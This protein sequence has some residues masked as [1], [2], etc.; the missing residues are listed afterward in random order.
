MDSDK[1]LGFGR[2][3]FAWRTAL[4]VPMA[5]YAAFAQSGPSS[6][7]GTFLDACKFGARGDGKTDDTKA[8]QQALDAAGGKSGA[9]FVPPGVYACSELRMRR[10]TALVGIPA[11]GYG[12]TG[13]SVLK[14]I[15]KGARCL[16]NITGA[17][18]AT[19]EGLSLEGGNL[20]EGVHGIFLDKP[21]YGKEED[22]FRIERS[23]VARF[24]GDAV[25]LTRVWCFSI[26]QSMLAFSKGDGVRCLGWDGF[27]I[28]NWF[29][30]NRGAGFG[31][32]GVAASLTMTGNRI[33]WNREAGI[34]LAAGNHINI[35]GNYIDRCGGSGIAITSAG[36]RQ[37]KHITVTGNVIYR[38]GKWSKLDTLENCHVRLEGAAGITCVGNSLVVGRDDGG[39]G[40]RSPSYGVVCQG[41]ENA[42]IKDNVLHDGALKTLVHDLGGHR[43]GV[44]VRDNP[45]R[46][47]QLPPTG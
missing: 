4:S 35:T 37:S 28:D 26:R 30:G 31:G 47:F 45:G 41:L 29:S 25:N 18:G 8:I 11:W 39:K 7:Q 3:K 38:S 1:D 42:I 13:G 6:D 24:S 40:N 16:I 22:T 27:I 44:I 2:R 32:R 14:L 15:D 23:K 20:G 9:V 33:E 17:I 46:L 10:N 21:D 12:N 36:D 5:G 19:I 43:D 34:L